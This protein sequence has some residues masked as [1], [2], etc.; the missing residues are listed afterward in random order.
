[1]LAGLIGTK[2]VFAPLIHG[3]VVQCRNYHLQKAADTKEQHPWPFGNPLLAMPVEF[4]QQ[5]RQKDKSTPH[6]VAAT[7]LVNAWCI[8]KS[9]N[10]SFAY[11]FD[12]IL[13]AYF[14]FN[15]KELSDDSHL[16]YLLCQ[17]DY[18]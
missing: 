10:K 9:I 3:F 5:D 14:I 7:I 1:M 17:S 18:V 16:F 6:G 4:L 11:K 2:P 15:T 12:K 8:V 13:V